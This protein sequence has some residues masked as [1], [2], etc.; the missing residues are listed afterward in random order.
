MSPASLGGG[1][2]FIFGTVMERNLN[3]QM[4]AIAIWDAFHKY[5]KR[6]NLSDE[7]CVHTLRH[8]YVKLL[9]KKL[10]LIYC[11]SKFFAT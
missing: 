4:T 9:L 5:R 6:A 11:E 8:A 2:R 7:F 3:Y 10:E 1:F